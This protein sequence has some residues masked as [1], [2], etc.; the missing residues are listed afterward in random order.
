MTTEYFFRATPICRSKVTI[1]D[2]CLDYTRG[3]YFIFFH[4]DL[5]LSLIHI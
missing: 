5:D 4:P 1:P 2:G 3:D